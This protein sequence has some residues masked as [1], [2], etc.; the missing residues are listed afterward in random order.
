MNNTRGCYN[1]M[2]H[3]IT[4]LILMSF[5]V[6]E[7]TARAMFKVLQETN[8]HTKTGFRRSER[9]Y[10]NKP[11]P[12]ESSVQGNE[13]G[14]TLWV[15]ISTKLIMM[16]LRKRY[17]VELL[18]TT[19]LILVSLVCFASVDNTNLPIIGGNFQQ[20]RILSIHFKKHLTSGLEGSQLQV[21][22]QHQQS[23]GVIQSTVCG[24]ELIGDTEQ[25]KKCWGNSY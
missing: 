5:G 13:I 24:L 19:T 23:L 22:N 3:S 20:D 11:I 16:M 9:V 21:G 7:E 4:I 17:R 6:A 25:K 15:S 8:H 1:R 12:Q 10:G 14:P 2:V 18:S